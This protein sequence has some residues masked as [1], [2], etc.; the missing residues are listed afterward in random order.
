MACSLLFASFSSNIMDI[1]KVLR[2]LTK[3][4]KEQKVKAVIKVAIL[5]I[6]WILCPTAMAVGTVIWLAYKAVKWLLV[7]DKPKGQ[8]DT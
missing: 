2:R 7:D 8:N 3:M 5:V 1:N 6:A 4:T